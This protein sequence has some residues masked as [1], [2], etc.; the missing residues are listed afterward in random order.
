[1]LA[2]N[3]LADNDFPPQNLKDLESIKQWLKQYDVS[4]NP[5][6]SPLQVKNYL[7]QYMPVEWCSSLINCVIALIIKLNILL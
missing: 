1:M 5:R 4:I 3:F 7:V 6:E 2:L